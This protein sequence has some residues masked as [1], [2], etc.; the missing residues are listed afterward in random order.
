MAAKHA[1]SLE[2]MAFI[3]DDLNDL[4]ALSVVGLPCA[5]GDAVPEVKAAAKLVA[6]NFGGRGAV[7]E[8]IEYIIKAQGQWEKLVAFYLRQRQDIFQ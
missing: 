8:I 2:E 1:L 4:P 3:G 7:R 6:K 5:V